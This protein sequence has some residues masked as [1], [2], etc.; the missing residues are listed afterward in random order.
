MVGS[1]WFGF[2]EHHVIL[3][4]MFGAPDFWKL[5]FELEAWRLLALIGLFPL[6]GGPFVA[7]LIMRAG[8]CWGA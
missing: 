8:L 5:P 7:V 2:N 6:T 3:G 1:G 4:S